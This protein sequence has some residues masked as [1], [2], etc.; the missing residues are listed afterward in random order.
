M[1][2]TSETLFSSGTIVGA[3]QA[4]AA[5]GHALLRAGIPVAAVASRTHSSAVRLATALQAQACS[6]VQAASS[7]SLVFVTTPDDVLGAVVEEIA[8]AGG[9]RPGQFV[10]HCS[11]VLDLA[12]LAPAERSGARVGVLHPVTPLTPPDQ[13]DTLVGKPMGCEAGG[14][15]GE[16]NWVCVLART[17]G[18]VPV[19]LAG[20]DRVLYHAA[21]CMAANL[22]VAMCASAEDVFLAAGLDAAAAQALVGSL[23]TSSARNVTRKGPRASLT[24]PAR[25]G[26]ANVIAQHFAGLQQI[27]EELAHA[28]KAVTRRILSLLPEGD[29]GDA[30]RERLGAVLD[31]PLDAF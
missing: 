15:A 16:E 7:A 20:V 1:S 24:G 19:S 28:Y 17:L 4:G 25:R 27:D 2:P 22:V 13:A 18:G 26:D 31:A 23:V 5:L 14:E 21:A 11:G 3:G 9:F 8:H 10:L 12:V 6:P 30:A 29:A